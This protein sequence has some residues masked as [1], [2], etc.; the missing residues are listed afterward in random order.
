[1]NNNSVKLCLRQTS[2]TLRDEIILAEG[3]ALPM[4]T[5][6]LTGIL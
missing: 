3:V 4:F 5:Y 1:M 6:S 2:I